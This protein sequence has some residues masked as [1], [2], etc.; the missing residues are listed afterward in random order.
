MIGR[1]SAAAS[2]S[3]IDSEA[4]VNVHHG[5]DA[6]FIGSTANE[7]HP[8][9]AACLHRNFSDGGALVIVGAVEVEHVEQI[10]DRRH[11]ARYIQVVVVRH[12][13]GQPI[14]AAGGGRLETPALD[15]FQH[16][17]LIAV[18]VDDNDA[19]RERRDHHERDP[20]SVTEEI[21]PL[22]EARIVKPPL[23]SCRS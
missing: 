20:R 22:N 18:G 4:Q 10:A 14:A 17:G 15:E 5:G 16:R 3:G 7:V 23:S 1:Q 12:R 19:G 9:G 2:A 21:E 11:V 8:I 13:T 6:A